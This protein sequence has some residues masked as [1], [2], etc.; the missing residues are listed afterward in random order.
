M[1]GGGRVAGERTLLAEGGA[2][3]AAEGSEVD[4][5][6]VGYAAVHGLAAH[7]TVPDAVCAAQ[8]RLLRGDE[9]KSVCYLRVDVCLDPAT[10]S[11]V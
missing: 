7:R 11:G 2:P 6:L 9:Q 8:L 4:V 3:G 1:Q 10:R 5:R